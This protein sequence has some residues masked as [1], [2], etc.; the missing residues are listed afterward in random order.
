M[1]NLVKQCINSQ[2]CWY[3]ACI[4]HSSIS[5]SVK[6]IA[7]FRSEWC[8]MVN[9][10]ATCF[11]C[12]RVLHM[13]EGIDSSCELIWLIC[14]NVYVY[15]NMNKWGEQTILLALLADVLFVI[16][17]L[18]IW[19]C[20]S[21]VNGSRFMMLKSNSFIKD[22]EIAALFSSDDPEKLFP[23]LSEIGHGSF[24]AVYSVSWL[25]GI[26]F[27]FSIFLELKCHIWCHE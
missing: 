17:S 6:L 25:P 2:C 13:K 24:G 9:E 18:Q 15:V 12:M 11:S 16:C 4:A 21:T 20:W 26:N 22:P 10:L 8:L 3:L 27:P 7:L 14:V 1:L 23:D 5:K 19:C